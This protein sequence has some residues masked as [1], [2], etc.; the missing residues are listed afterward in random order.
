MGQRGPAGAMRRF[1]TIETV[2]REE[3]AAVVA[4]GTAALITN[5]EN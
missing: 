4:A 1:I 3:R 2:W 5:Q